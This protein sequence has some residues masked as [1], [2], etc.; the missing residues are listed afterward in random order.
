MDHIPLPRSD[1]ISHLG[2]RYLGECYPEL[3]YDYQGF[4]GFPSRKAFKEPSLTRSEGQR[5]TSEEQA[6]ILQSWC[7]FGLIVEVF[8]VFGKTMKIEDFVSRGPSLI[9][10]LTSCRIPALLRSAEQL[11]R[12]MDFDTRAIKY[13]VIKPW[14]VTSG[15]VVRRL[16]TETPEDSEWARIHL[17]TLAVGEYIF[18]A[19]RVS[20]KCGDPTPS[21]WWARTSLL[22]TLMRTAGWC[23]SLTAALIDEEVSQS[24][25]YY[26]SRMDRRG[27]SIDHA[28]C[29]SNNCTL[30]K[31]D[32]KTYQTKHTEVCGG[33]SSC[34]YLSLEPQQWTHLLEIV[35]KQQVPL[36]VVEK[37]DD[38]A[39][40]SIRVSSSEVNGADASKEFAGSKVDSRNTDS[41][42]T[43]ESMSAKPGL[44]A[45]VCISHVWSE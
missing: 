23:P 31:L 17:S 4:I 3:T 44:K 34:P 25:I 15:I 41:C 43:T 11:T 27:A 18:N 28:E 12:D 10:R 33:T 5:T 13:R 6:C 42:L 20:L 2:V 45:Y 22:P 26:I 21:P 29:T 37:G 14:F 32:L 7:Y 1:A 36:I 19:L 38:E 9:P 40:L 30:D 8:K 24:F 16:A 35:Q 39:T